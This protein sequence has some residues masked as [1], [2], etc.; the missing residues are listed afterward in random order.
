MKRGRSVR[1]PLV[2]H[3]PYVNRDSWMFHTSP[4]KRGQPVCRMC[5]N[6][7]DGYRKLLDEREDY[8]KTG[9]LPINL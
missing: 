3:E 2:T 8:G 7:V 9:N 4:V 5:E 1:L 6:F